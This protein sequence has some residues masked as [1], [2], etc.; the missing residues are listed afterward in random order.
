MQGSSNQIPALP[1]LL[2]TCISCQS[3]LGKNESVEHFPVG[4]RLAFD[5]AK[6]RL[7]VVCAKCGRWNLTPIEERWEAIE[8]CERQFRE[9]RLRAST[10]QIGLAKLREGTDL[11]RIG[12]P[13]RPEFAAWRYS[14]F[15]QRRRREEVAWVVGGL[16]VGSAITFAGA[17]LAGVGFNVVGIARAYLPRRNELGRADR[18]INSKFFAATGKKVRRREK[19]DIRIIPSDEAPCWGMRFA[20]DAKFADFTGQD[21]IHAAQMVSPAVNAKGA[22]QS[23]INDAVKS[24]ERAPSLDEFFLSVLKYG[25]GRGWRYT[26]LKDYPEEMRLAFE[27]AS[28][29]ESE[30]RAL[31]GELDRLEQDWKEAEEIA[32]IADNLFLPKSVTDWID[33]QRVR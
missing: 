25:Q 3:A 19:A 20:Y 16:A 11:I 29:E 6:G 14:R 2:Q 10:D 15:F 9:T 5:G 30:R 18:F 33:R 8:E 24:L 1:V 23:S 13:L 27:I 7:W 28:H 26:G 21:A 12:S 4:R 32:V 22:S 17:G 31:D